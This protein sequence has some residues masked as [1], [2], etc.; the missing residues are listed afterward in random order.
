MKLL[1]ALGIDF[2]IFLIQ[3]LNFLLLF[4]ILKWLFFK[5][6]IAA[7]HKEKEDAEKI[8][9]SQELIE[10]EKEKW[11]KQ[12]E[13][14]MVS[15]RARIENMI[16]EAEDMVRKMKN[17]AKEEAFKEE[18]EAIRLVKEHSQQILD[19]YKDKLA[20]DYKNKVIRGVLDIFNNDFSQLTKKRI[21]DS[22]WQK[23]IK[24]ANRLNVPEVSK[25]VD[26]IRE[27]KR[28]EEIKFRHMEIKIL[29]TS[30]FPLT[31]SQASELS[32]VLK[33][34]F[35]SKFRSVKLEQKIDKSLISGFI[36]DFRGL[37][38]EENL[39]SKIEKLFE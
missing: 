25:I 1:G 4:L 28:R 33:E 14:E 36:L 23:L 13:Q 10:E 37:S 15:A 17:K 8:K 21:Q 6:F 27:E 30:A 12:K 18:E 38:L 39:R 2:K 3:A 22:L 26:K 7:L 11:Q 29:I 5:P 19:E 9:K 24:R 20:D 31:R 35:P 16:S 34:K 32:E